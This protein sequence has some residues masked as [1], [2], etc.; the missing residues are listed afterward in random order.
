MEKKKSHVLRL[1]GTIPGLPLLVSLIVVILG[2]VY[3]CSRAKTEY[4]AGWAAVPP[5]SRLTDNRHDCGNS[6]ELYLACNA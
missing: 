3:Q 5:P 2:L 1:V 6:H 4:G